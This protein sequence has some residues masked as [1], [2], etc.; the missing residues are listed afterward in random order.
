MKHEAGLI[1]SPFGYLVFTS[2]RESQSE[3]AINQNLI[4]ICIF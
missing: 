3:R 1:G 4:R 2:K